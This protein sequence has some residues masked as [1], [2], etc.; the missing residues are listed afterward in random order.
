MP[1]SELRETSS[2]QLSFT[3]LPRETRD[4]IYFFVLQSP[5][6]KPTSPV[7][8]SQNGDQIVEIR[9]PGLI[10]NYP[11]KSHP[12]LAC[13]NL[14][15]CNRQ[16]SG[17]IR[18]LLAR[19]SGNLLYKLDV[20][21][22][23]WELW[24]LW[25][26]CPGPAKHIRNLDMDLRLVTT[27]DGEGTFRHERRPNY[28]ETVFRLLV[29]ILSD[30]FHYGP[31]FLAERPLVASD[32]TVDTLRVTLSHVEQ[33][34]NSGPTYDVRQRILS[35]VKTQM[36]LLAH[37]GVLSG[38]VSKLELVMWTP[39]PGLQKYDFDVEEK[40]FMGGIAGPKSWA[41]HGFRWGP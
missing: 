13:A 24:P 31:R 36:G 18:E 25:I 29:R 26:N 1:S 8:P 22:K 10:T 15:R 39:N 4:Q 5:V 17:E 11:P 23:D 40:E 21:A 30:F 37:C 20:M 19:K 35:K 33:Q 32:L 16:I 9:S 12:T 38:K 27:W 6:A 3:S 41:N 14:L 34:H 2:T 28:P 7:S